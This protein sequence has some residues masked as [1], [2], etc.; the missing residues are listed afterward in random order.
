MIEVQNFCK[1]YKSH[2]KTVFKVQDV[3]F[4]V[5]KGSITGLVGP[6]GSGKSTTM[7]CIVGLDRPTSGRAT[8]GGVEYRNLKSP[9]TTVGALLDGKAFHKSRSARHHLKTVAQFM[10][11]KIQ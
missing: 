4:T 10:C 7:R 6:N 2:S 5:E 3:C 11:L 8:I 1:E 9:L